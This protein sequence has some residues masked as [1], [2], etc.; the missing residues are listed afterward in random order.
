[1]VTHP[2]WAS[3][4]VYGAITTA[5]TAATAINGVLTRWAA[6]EPSTRALVIIDTFET[7]D[8]KG[9]IANN[10]WLVSDADARVRV[11]GKWDVNAKAGK[12]WIKDL[13][14]LRTT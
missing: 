7:R 11:R 3:K 14:V 10:M 6:V 5:L 4:Y 8:L 2:T 9:W 12:L 1:M 13:M